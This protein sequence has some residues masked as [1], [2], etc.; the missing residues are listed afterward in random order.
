MIMTLLKMPLNDPGNIMKIKIII[1]IAAALQAQGSSIELSGSLHGEGKGFPDKGLYS[2]QHYGY[3]S[4]ELAPTLTWTSQSGYTLWTFSP[5]GRWDPKDESRTHMDIRE[6]SWIWHKNQYEARAGILKVFWGVTES[7]HLVDVINQTDV[8]E[9]QDGENK[10]GQPLLSFGW[11]SSV[12]QWDIYY[13]P[14]MRK[15]AFAEKDSRFQLPYNVSSDLYES[16][17]KKAYPSFALRYSHYFANF[18]GGIYY[19]HGTNREPQLIPKLIGTNIEFR[20]KYFIM[21][22]MGVDLQYI[23]E[24]L[25]L[26]LEYRYRN[27]NEG[28]WAFVPGFEYSYYNIV[29]LFDLGLLM[30]YSRDERG[31]EGYSFLQ[32]DIFSGFRLGFNDVSSTEVLAGTFVDMELGTVYANVEA[33]RR[34]HNRIVVSLEIRNGIY[35][36]KRDPLNVYRKDSYGQLDIGWFF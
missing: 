19:F 31:L 28:F 23:W 3:G 10:L 29:S 24:A 15:R 32:N 16:G 4:L 14:W 27:S 9:N 35:I 1:F 33:S 34:V 30:E 2:E 11:G 7:N 5:W 26:K 13:L 8:L 6:F 21:D 36:S 12:G 25:V 20:S 18:E 17:I 22:Q